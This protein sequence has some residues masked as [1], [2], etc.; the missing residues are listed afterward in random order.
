MFVGPYGFSGF[1]KTVVEAGINLSDR[2]L[3][4]LCEIKRE[5]ISGTNDAATAIEGESPG[6]I[7]YDIFAQADFILSLTAD[8]QVSTRT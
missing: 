8:G 3:P 5:P 6:V 2:A 4:C 7:R 1:A